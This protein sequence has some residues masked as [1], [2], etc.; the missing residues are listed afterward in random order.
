[1]SE[2]Y[3]GVQ[4]VDTRSVSEMKS[5]TRY[6]LGVKR[7]LDVALKESD[8]YF[9]VRTSL[10]VEYPMNPDDSVD[11]S[12]LRYLIRVKQIK[13]LT[14]DQREQLV[15]FASRAIETVRKAMHESYTPGF[16]VSQ[17]DIVSMVI[18]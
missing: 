3:S 8:I 4:F 10:D 11:M 16:R 5:G 13:Q 6:A 17:R 12:R 7:V 2:T 14:V 1:M 15:D 9:M 18:E